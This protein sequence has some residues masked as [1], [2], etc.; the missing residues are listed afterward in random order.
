MVRTDNVVGFPG[1]KVRRTAG[2]LLVAER[3]TEARL[4][5]RLTQTELALAIG[6]SRQAVSTYELGTKSP[7]P[8]TM[9]AI[10]H[11][12]GQPISFFTKTEHTAFGAFSPNFFRKVGADTKRRNLAC[13]VYAKWFAA[14]VHAFDEIANLPAVDVPQFEPEDGLESA[15]TEEEIETIAEKVRQHF[16]LG[17]GPITNVIR[18]LEVKGVSIC[19]LEIEGENIEAFSYWSGER[20]FIFLASDKGSAARARFDVAHE[21]GHLCLHGWVSA[22]E[23]EDAARLKQM[24]AEANRFAGAFLLPRKSFPNEVYSPRAEAFIPLKERWKVAIQAMVYRCKDLGLFDERQVTN[25]YKQIS[26]K[27]WRTKEPLDGAC[28]IPLE[29]PTLLRTIAELILSKGQTTIEEICNG[30]AFAPSVIEQMWGLEAGVLRMPHETEFLP[31][32]K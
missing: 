18:L 4:A 3:L 22:V 26:F 12:L 27:K 17:W 7:E 6:V 2:R 25:I 21:L 23:I 24:E 10:S 16:G 9:H 30:L 15:Y 13:E 20:P 5:A 29:R 32:L 14:S 28:G 19:R 11:V 8:A 1:P 31:T